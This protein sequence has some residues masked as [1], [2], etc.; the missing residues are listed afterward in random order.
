LGME[1]I[2]SGFY[3]IDTEQDNKVPLHREIQSVSKIFDLHSLGP[4]FF[5]S[6]SLPLWERLTARNQ[7]RA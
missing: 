6:L 7:S 3:E 5:T 4:F 2:I 1:R